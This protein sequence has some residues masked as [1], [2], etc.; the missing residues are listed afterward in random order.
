MQ[1]DL[2]AGAVRPT[3]RK[4]VSASRLPLLLAVL[5]FQVAK[6]LLVS[7]VFMA[8]RVPSQLLS[9]NNVERWTDHFATAVPDPDLNGGFRSSRSS[10]RPSSSSLKVY[11]IPGVSLFVKNDQR[12]EE[13]REGPC[14][15]TS[16]SINSNWITNKIIITLDSMR[17][18]T[19]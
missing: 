2:V 3:L 18:P 14:A 1:S 9:L 4:L 19:L 5:F 13:F 10:A 11:V 16:N 12:P 17:I 7:Y 8:Y 15:T 6:I